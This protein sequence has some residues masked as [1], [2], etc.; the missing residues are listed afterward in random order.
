MICADHIQGLHGLAH[1]NAEFCGVVIKVRGV[2]VCVEF[3][4]YREHQLE[5][6]ATS[7][8]GQSRYVKDLH[9]KT[10]GGAW[11][12]SVSNAGVLM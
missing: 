12:Q 4:C 7:S 3:V 5:T 2:G 11:Q 10:Y 8:P 9:T 6:K 1:L